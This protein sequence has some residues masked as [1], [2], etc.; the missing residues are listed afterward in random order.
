MSKKLDTIVGKIAKYK[1][2]LEHG[3]YS[4][5]V[6]NCEDASLNGEEI[7]NL[8]GEIFPSFVIKG[9]YSF[10][11]LQK[12][13]ISYDSEK[14]RTIEETIYLVGESIEALL[15]DSEVVSV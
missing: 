3:E 5:I 7:S 2:V 8:N 12:V 10:K 6:I 4:L 11:P 1:G 13:E 9:K 15:E 14:T